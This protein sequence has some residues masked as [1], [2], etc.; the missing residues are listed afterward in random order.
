MTLPDVVLWRAALRRAAVGDL[1]FRRQH[2]IGPYILD[3]YCPKARL[4]VEV[5]GAAHDLP[6][7]AAHDAQGA[8][9]L[10]EQGI[11][12]LRVPAGDVLRDE[13]LDGVLDTIIA[14]AGARFD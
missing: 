1:R 8:A 13:A 11:R 5:D 12:V 4:A 10:R 7:Q 9:W 3:F 6:Q 14:M 2:P